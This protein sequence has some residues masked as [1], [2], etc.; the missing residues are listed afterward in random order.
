[1]SK[2]YFQCLYCKYAL[3]LTFPYMFLKQK[4]CYLDVGKRKIQYLLKQKT[5]QWILGELVYLLQKCIL[6]N[7][8]QEFIIEYMLDKVKESLIFSVIHTVLNRK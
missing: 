4:R 2:S 6:F 7:I 5:R 1:M 3:K 8:V